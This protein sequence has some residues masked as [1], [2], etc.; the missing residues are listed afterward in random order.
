MTIGYHKYRPK[1]THRVEKMG[2]FMQIL[3]IGP[4]IDF[5][6]NFS[7]FSGFSD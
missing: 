1:A 2:K 4:K 7:D 6:H 5:F 3:D